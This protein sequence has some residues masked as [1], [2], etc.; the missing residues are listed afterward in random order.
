[1]EKIV[2]AESRWRRE[3]RASSDGWRERRQGWKWPEAPG[4]FG[5]GTMPGCPCREFSDFQRTETN[6]SKKR[7]FKSGGAPN[8]GKQAAR[9]MLIVK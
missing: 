6:I 4:T 7:L 3:R 1:M 5:L 2:P 9:R 8:A